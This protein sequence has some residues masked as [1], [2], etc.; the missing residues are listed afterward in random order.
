V[1]RTRRRKEDDSIEYR[2]SGL[3]IG[4]E[5]D[6]GREFGGCRLVLSLLLKRLKLREKTST[7]FSSPPVRPPPS[8]ARPPLAHRPSA[9]LCPQSRS[10][11]RPPQSPPALSPI[12]APPS[13][14]PSHHKPPLPSNHG[15]AAT[16]VEYV[17]ATTPS[18][19]PLLAPSNAVGTSRTLTC[20]S[21]AAA[22]I[23]GVVPPRA[24]PVGAG[25]R[26]PLEVH[27]KVGP[28]AYKNSN[29][30]SQVLPLLFHLSFHP[31]LG[32]SLVTTDDEGCGS[33]RFVK[34][35]W[36]GNQIPAKSN[37]LI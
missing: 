26:A 2:R 36:G 23:F 17:A 32:D 25:G 6:R 15:A 7:S 34:G 10:A 20:R 30:Q 27:D 4:D 3:R 33:T 14:A 19:T 18:T 11:A 21:T 13:S 37:T 35:Q 8:T 16:V 12:P 9:S 31:I 24:L 29:L 22:G 28:P 5:Y 1:S